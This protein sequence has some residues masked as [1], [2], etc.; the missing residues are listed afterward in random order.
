MTSERFQ[1]FTGNSIPQADGIVLTP[2]CERP[3]IRSEHNNINIILVSAQG[4]PKLTGIGIPEANRLVPTPS[5]KDATI[6]TECNAYDD[7]CMSSNRFQMCT[8]ERVP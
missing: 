5:S 8:C 4:M 3:S 6:S 7:I 1:V 2:A